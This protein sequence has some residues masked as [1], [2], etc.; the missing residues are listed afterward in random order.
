MIGSIQIDNQSSVKPLFPTI[1][2]PRLFKNNDEMTMIEIDINMNTENS[3]IKYIE[4]IDFKF[5]GMI[6]KCDD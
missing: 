4:D 1:L 5:S 3:K 6:V 2:Q